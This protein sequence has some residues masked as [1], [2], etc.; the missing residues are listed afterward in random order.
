MMCLVNLD[1]Y[2]KSID[3][4]AVEQF[5]WLGFEFENKTTY[6]ANLETIVQNEDA[7]KKFIFVIIRH[8]LSGDVLEQAKAVQDITL[9]FPLLHLLLRHVNT[10]ARETRNRGGE[11]EEIEPW[12]LIIHG[13]ICLKCRHDG[14]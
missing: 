2:D 8:L 1:V 5:P 4:L 6:T 13:V 14:E 3:E 11:F 9:T 7:Y 12:K 10:V